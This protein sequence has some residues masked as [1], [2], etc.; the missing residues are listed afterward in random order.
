GSPWYS[1]S[2]SI[3]GIGM[4]ACLGGL[5][6]VVMA[7]LASAAWAHTQHQ[8][9]RCYNAAA[10]NDQRIEACTAIIQS[11]QAG[12]REL[13]VAFNNRGVSYYNEHQYNRAIAVFS[14]ALRIDPRY[15]EALYNRG[16]AYESAGAPDSAIR[17]FDDAIKVNP[18]YPAAF[19]SRGSI[20]YLHGQF[21]RAIADFSQAI[22]LDP[23]YANAWSSRCIARAR[24]DEL[25]GALSDCDE[26]LQLSPGNA[27]T[28]D[29][30]GF[31]HLKMK[32]Y[33]HAIADYDAALNADPKL[34]S[35]LFG[36][37]VAENLKSGSTTVGK[38]DIAAAKQIDPDIAK[39][40]EQYGIRAF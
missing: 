15:S 40:F 10:T 36:R 33:D 30:R 23:S 39:R 3:G 34:A 21:D 19:N 1:L 20:Y 14:G 13:A 37:G 31:V 9:G 22:R 12:G 18:N 2:Q 11:G 17:D 35:S 8:A 32:D 5:L 27:A 4:R 26:A 29:G 38:A 24:A 16:N 25:Q 7:A 6:T 28:L